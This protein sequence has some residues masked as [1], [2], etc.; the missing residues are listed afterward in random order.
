[1]KEFLFRH[2]RLGGRDETTIVAPSG[3]VIKPVAR[4]RSGTGNHGED[5]Y[6]E[7]VLEGAL[8]LV[9]EVSNSGIDRS[10]IEF[11]EKPSA[12]QN[13]AARE[14]ALNHLSSRNLDIGK[15]VF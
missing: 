11:P 3:D 14:F 12:A 6:L 10:R 15:Y 7:R 8:V 5:V 4:R 2:T 13:Q 1:M 9:V